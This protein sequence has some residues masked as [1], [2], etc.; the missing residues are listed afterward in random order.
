MPNVTA[1]AM[2]HRHYRCKSKSLSSTLDSHTTITISVL[3]HEL[4]ETQIAAKYSIPI[5]GVGLLYARAPTLDVA[6]GKA[7]ILKDSQFKLCVHLCIY[8]LTT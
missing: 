2:N 6:S 3:Y 1:V 7:D 8:H 5:N 4:C